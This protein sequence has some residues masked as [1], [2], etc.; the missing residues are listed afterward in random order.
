MRSIALAAVGTALALAGCGG[1]Q[2]SVGEDVSPEQV[3]SCLKRAGVKTGGTRDLIAEDAGVGSVVA[4]LDRNRA[5]V[6]IE[7]SE[8]D[9]ESTASDYEAFIENPD[10]RLTQEGSVVVAWD[11]TPTD[12]ETRAIEGC[13]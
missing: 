8:G 12:Q 11:K 6:V 7:R 2:G 10:E 4:E 13:L 5:N 9:A 1:G 3:E